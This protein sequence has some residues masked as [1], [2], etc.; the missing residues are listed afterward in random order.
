LNDHDFTKVFEKILKGEEPLIRTFGVDFA[1][2]PSVHVIH[3]FEFP[4]KPQDE[5]GRLRA[6]I[7]RLEGWINA[8]QNERAVLKGRVASL[9]RLVEGLNELLAM[10]P[11]PAPAW[12]KKHLKFLIFVCHPD[13][14]PGK[15]EA[16][17]V[18]RELLAL[19][20]RP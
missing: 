11:V 5:T 12:I 18:T 7:L 3:E 1:R 4:T 2:D 15:G 8:L 14:N 20:G 19:R 13:R 6:Q 10:V 16:A 9:E 17:E